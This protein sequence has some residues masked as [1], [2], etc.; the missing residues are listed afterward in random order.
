MD[1]W[2]NKR[3]RFVPPLLLSVGSFVF[4]LV[5]GKRFKLIRNRPRHSLV[6]QRERHLLPLTRQRFILVQPREEE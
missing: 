4:N 5:R 6:L 1:R 3:R 2:R